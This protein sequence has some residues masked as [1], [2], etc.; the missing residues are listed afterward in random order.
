MALKPETEAHLARAER[1][2]VV[3]R[4][5]CDPRSSLGLQP[6]PF[7]WAAIAAF[8]AAVHYV[9]AFIWERFGQAPG[10]HRTRRGFVARIAPLNRVLRA[11]DLLADL[12][13]QARYATVFRSP[14]QLPQIVQSRLDEI[15][16]VVYQALG[17]S[18]P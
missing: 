15:R 7:E 5:L 16:A 17:S 12:G 18:P 2:R 1:N 13:W 14:A 10:D 8:Y 11:Y 3:A 6:Q 4:A 9:N